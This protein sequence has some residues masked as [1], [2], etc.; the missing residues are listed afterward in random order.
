MAAPDAPL[1]LLVCGGRH[2][3]DTDAVNRALTTASPE[4]VVTGAC[5]TGA[6]RH[7]ADWCQTNGVPLIQVPALWVSEGSGAGP[8]RNARMLRYAMTLAVGVCAFPGGRGTEGMCELARASKVRV[9]RV[10]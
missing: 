9:W 5:P 8:I 10:R 4:I 1:I 7:A 2:Y 6:D 3:A